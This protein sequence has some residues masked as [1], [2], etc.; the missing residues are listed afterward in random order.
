MQLPPEAFRLLLANRT[1][2]FKRIDPRTMPI[3]KRDLVTVVTRWCHRL[4]LDRPRLCR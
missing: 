3:G 2:Q 4:N 1:Q